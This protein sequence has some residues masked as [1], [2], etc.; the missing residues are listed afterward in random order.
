MRGSPV[1][2]T[3]FYFLFPSGGYRDVLCVIC[4]TFMLYVPFIKMHDLLQL[5]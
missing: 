2:L 1:E 3:R 5:K 4:S